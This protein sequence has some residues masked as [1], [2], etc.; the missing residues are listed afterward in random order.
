MAI[1]VKKY[2]IC[3]ISR[4]FSAYHYIHFNHYYFKPARRFF[5][6]SYSK[7]CSKGKLFFSMEVDYLDLE[8]FSG[9]TG[10]NRR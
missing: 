2:D 8:W 5:K 1:F 10:K 7:S 9:K 6:Q 4:F 3:Q